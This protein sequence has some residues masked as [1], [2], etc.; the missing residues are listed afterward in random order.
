MHSE[1]LI[2][3]RSNR[4]R[5]KKQDRYIITEGNGKPT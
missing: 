4:E 1:H 3:D 5:G 2:V